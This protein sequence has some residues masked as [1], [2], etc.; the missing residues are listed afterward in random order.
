M[1][2][3]E[4]EPKE[5]IDYYDSLKNLNLI[6]KHSREQLNLLRKSFSGLKEPYELQD[7]IK[8]TEKSVMPEYKKHSKTS[9]QLSTILNGLNLTSVNMLQTKNER[10]SPKQETQEVYVDSTE[11]V[12]KRKRRKYTIVNYKRHSDGSLERKKSVIYKDYYPKNGKH[13]D[14]N[15]NPKI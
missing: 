11:P 14:K 4:R 8:A 7:A 1:T 3:Y 6:R 2:S 5:Y 10:G 12:F 13:L 15:V 9:G